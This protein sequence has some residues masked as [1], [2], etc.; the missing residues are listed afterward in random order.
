MFK[1]EIYKVD[2]MQHNLNDSD[3]HGSKYNIRFTMLSK[4]HQKR[5]FEFVFQGL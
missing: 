2:K 5:Y 3:Q 1:N 4:K